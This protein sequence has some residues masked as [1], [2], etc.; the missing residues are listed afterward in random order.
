M[1]RR[2]YSE[3]YCRVNPSPE[4]RSVAV[5]LV[6][7]TQLL[8]LFAMLY[9]HTTLLPRLKKWKQPLHTVGFYGD[10]AKKAL[11]PYTILVLSAISIAG[12]FITAYGMTKEIYLSWYSYLTLDVLVLSLMT[13]WL[14]RADWSFFL[15]HSVSYAEHKYGID[16]K[17]IYKLLKRRGLPFFPLLEMEKELALEHRAVY[18]I[19]PCDEDTSARARAYVER[20]L[21][22]E[23]QMNTAHKFFTTL[24]ESLDSGDKAIHRRLNK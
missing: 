12:I 1:D 19:D 16:Y 2:A 14:N 3:A 13:Y 15:K 9:I 23:E 11:W 24:R 8:F 18:S 22:H 7:T 20:I 21:L 10:Y 6:N 17:P 5:F 4:E